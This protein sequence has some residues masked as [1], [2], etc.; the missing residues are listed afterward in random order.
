[1][2]PYRRKWHQLAVFYLA[3][4]TA[5][6]GQSEAVRLAQAWRHLA[7]F[8]RQQM[9]E[10]RTPGV[11]LAITNREGLLHLATF[12]H[13]DA[14]ARRPV[15]SET[16]FQIGSISKSFTAV[17]LLQL[18]DEG[19]LALDAPLVRY[20]PWFSIVTAHPPFTVHDL[21]THTAGLP[22][23]RDDIPSSRF[24]VWALRER[25][26][27]APPGAHWAYSNVGYQVLGY[28]LEALEGADYATILRRRIFQPLGMHHSEPTITF[29]ARPR[30]AVG[31][32]TAYDDRPA[33]RSH[34]L[35]P[36]PWFEYGAG[37]GSIAATPAELAA[38][39]RMLLNRGAVAGGRLLS[40]ESFALLTQRFVRARG[41]RWYGYGLEVW[42]QDGRTWFGHGGAMVGYRA[43]LLGDFSSGL[44]VV[45]MINGPGAPDRIAEFALECVHA[46]LQ[47][48]PLPALPERVPPTRVENATDYAGTFT[49]PDGR[50]V[51]FI[52]S[53]D[54]LYLLRV[55][56][57]IRLERRGPDRFYTPHADF[58]LFPIVFT[59]ATAE[60]GQGP[61]VEV[62]HGATA[63]YHE[64]YTGP[65][66]FEVPVEWKFYEGHYSTTNPW[67]SNFRVLTRKGKLW[68]VF[69][70]GEEE[71]LVPL[72]PGLF[73]VGSEEHSAER[74][75]F[76]AVVEGR[77]LRA[78]FSGVDFY[79]T[80]TP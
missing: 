79:R 69:P 74:L 28:L 22:R 12:G 26:T 21:L 63:F 53:G 77:A 47:L 2:R 65:R 29:A 75:Q 48:R 3:W 33:H 44:G 46:A 60:H 67:L 18:H 9:A 8:V 31:H 24:S 11:A 49:A 59:R 42:D 55:G 80:F 38:Y 14:A 30:M 51:Q 16:L 4:A 43:M 66:R 34:P 6:V 58:A 54:G 7:A 19:K 76:D 40:E 5:A 23:D 27:G 72:A 78:N 52:A 62:H 61:V 70:S 35:V 50:S 57:R 39:L 73:R 25:I 68:V 20:W 1:M 10:S 56:Q 64:R 37:D 15:T 45:V 32:Q 36:A 71:E 13:A 17:A 41:D